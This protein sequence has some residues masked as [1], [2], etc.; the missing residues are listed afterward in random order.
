MPF[1]GSCLHPWAQQ[2]QVGRAQSYS[3]EQPPMPEGG[4]TARQ[5]RA[6][7]EL[8]F[9]GSGIQMGHSPSLSM[10]STLAQEGFWVFSG[11]NR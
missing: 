7:P 1:S 5:Q 8:G 11:K 4:W 6:G 10:A 2:V 3:S 9:L